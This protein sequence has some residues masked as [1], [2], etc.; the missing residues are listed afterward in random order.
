M[1][2]ENSYR[3][4]Y[5]LAGLLGAIGGGLAVALVTKAIPTMM[6]GMMGTMLARMEECGFD[7]AEM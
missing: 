3:K 1:D 7:P 6:S 2:E 4:G 5:V